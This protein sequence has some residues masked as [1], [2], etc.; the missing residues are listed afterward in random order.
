ML[1]KEN[2]DNLLSANTAQQLEVISLHLNKISE[3]SSNT[4]PHTNDRKVNQIL[5]KFE[6]VFNGLGKLKGHQITVNIDDSVTPVAEPHRRIPY[7][8]RKKVA[9]AIKQ[10]EQDDN[11]EIVP[12]TQATPWI[13]PIVTVPKKD[14]N[15]VRICVDMRKAN[16]AIQRVRFL[17]PTMNDVSNDLN[18]AQ[19]FSKLDLNQ[20]FRQLELKEESRFI[21]TFSTHVGTYRYKRL[22]YCMNCSSELF[23]HTLQTTLTG[24][25]GVRNL[26]DDIV[27]FGK[28]KE[29]HDK[30]TGSPG[31]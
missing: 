21:T 12:D 25:Q 2:S 10:L 20:A 29:E 16:K 13:S 26:H 8:L 9:E 3:S 7:H 27:V 22:N 1:D 23:Q 11:I 19:Y 24:I 17:I 28:S 15:S 6:K 18:G 4:S 14:G 30:A 31:S 5:E